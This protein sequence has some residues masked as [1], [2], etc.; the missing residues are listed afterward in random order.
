MLPGDS[1]TAEEAGGPRAQAF[2]AGPACQSGGPGLARRP[3]R[4]E[5]RPPADWAGAQIPAAPNE[6]EG[7]WSPQ[8]LPYQ[9]LKGRLSGYCPS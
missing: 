2:A 9:A 6:N 8:P 7:A 1:A 3:H 5:Q 4:G